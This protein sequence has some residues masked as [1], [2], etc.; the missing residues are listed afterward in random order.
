MVVI[1]SAQVINILISIIRMKVVAVLLGPT[2]V[3]LLG[4]YNNLQQMVGNTA[5]LGM[6]SSGVRQIANARGD[7]TTLNRVSRVLL[8][9][10]MVQGTLAMAAVWLLREPI[11]VWLTGDATLST[12]IGLVGIAVLLMLLSTAYTALLQGLRRIGDLGRVTVI[13]AIVGTLIGLFAIWQFGKAGLIWFLLAQPFASFL[14]ALLFVRRLPE[15]GNQT[16]FSFADTWSTWKPMARLGSA[17][18]LGGLANTATLLFVRSAITQELDL[19]A[20]GYF[21]AAWGITMTYVGFLLG[22]MGADYFPRLTE[23]IHDR[24]AASRLMNDQAQLGL[25]I[26]GPVLLLL[27]GWAPWVIS[28]LYAKEFG[29]AATLLQWQSVGNV[30]KLASWAMSFAVVAAA[31]AKIYFFMELSFNIVFLALVWWL[32]PRIG[33][34]ITGVAF[35]LGYV[36]YFGTVY[37]IVRHLRGFRWQALSL[38]LLGL[39]VVLAASLLGLSFMAPLAGI[40]ASSLLAAMTGIIG[41]RVVLEK[42]G[43]AGRLAE[44]CFKVYARLGWPI[45]SEI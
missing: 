21:A 16:S 2:G 9:A 6:G 24:D 26:G 4:I 8:A 29:P 31:H 15:R 28:L 23:V 3:G 41:V 42:I 20:A 40:V 38:R 13:G 18:M 45:R 32:L 5:G 34:E 17:F 43:P 12:E 37:L 11:T 22:A 25:A 36:T 30:F 39:H 10:H 19:E 27:I 33:L 1:G 44:K 7:A 14:A 35:L